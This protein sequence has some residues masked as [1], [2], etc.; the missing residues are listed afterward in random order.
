[1]EAFEKHST[2][3]SAMFVEHLA[4]AFPAPI[5][6]IQ[7]DNGPEFTNRYT[8]HTFFDVHLERSF[9]FKQYMSPLFIYCY[10]KKILYAKPHQ[11]PLKSLNILGFIFAHITEYDADTSHISFKIILICF[12]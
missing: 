4:K 3:S 12:M 10:S 5:E 2:Y 6:C 11:N 1:M 7:A 8:S 9:S